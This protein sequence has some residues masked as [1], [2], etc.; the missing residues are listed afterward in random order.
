MHPGSHN[1]SRSMLTKASRCRQPAVH[2][3]HLG[4][5]CMNTDALHSHHN[6]VC[7]SRSRMSLHNVPGDGI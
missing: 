6:Q 2:L 4:L 1:T 3:H 7:R 5:N